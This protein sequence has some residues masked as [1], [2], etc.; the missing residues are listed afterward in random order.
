MI[1]DLSVIGA[2]TPEVRRD[3]NERTSYAVKSYFEWPGSKFILLMFLQP[4]TNEI[5]DAFLISDAI[6]VIAQMEKICILERAPPVIHL[7]NNLRVEDTASFS[8][9]DEAPP[10]TAAGSYKFKLK[11]KGTISSR[12]N[13]LKSLCPFLDKLDIMRVRG[14]L[15]KS[16]LDEQVKHPIVLPH[17][18]HL[19]HLIV[20][21]AHERTLHG[22]PQLMSNFLSWHHILSDIGVHIQVFLQH[23]VQKCGQRLFWFLHVEMGAL[24][25]TLGV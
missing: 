12:T 19:T 10:A 14:R 25:K 8:K 15:E 3:G 17:S 2:V 23:V 9:V 1:I 21:D 6:L 4:S 18:S 13:Q 22:G 20:S 7:K 11:E 5:T 24:G 16:Q